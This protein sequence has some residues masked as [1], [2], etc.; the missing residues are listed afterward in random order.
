MQESFKFFTE[1]TNENI[2]DLKRMIQ[3]PD[4]ERV[5][6]YGGTAYVDMLKKKLER[7]L[8]IVAIKDHLFKS[9]L[10]GGR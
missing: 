8:K 10:S 1:S 7:M 2:E 4:P 5:E 3:N 9:K 6:Q